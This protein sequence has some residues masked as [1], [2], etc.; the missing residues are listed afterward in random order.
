LLTGRLS[1]DDA[2]VLLPSARPV[3]VRGLQVHGERQEEVV[4]GQRVAVNLAGV[5]LTDVNRG[6]T[7]T[8]ADAVTVTRHADV[9][10]ELLRTG[11]PLKH[12]ARIRFHQGTRELLGRVVLPGI[13]EV[14]PGS[15]TYARLHL[16]APAVLVRGD[17]FILRACSPPETIAGGTILDPAAWRRGVRTAA[18]LARFASLST[19]EID[20]VTMM[21]DETERAGL[22][23]AQLTGRAGV[24]WERRRAVV[25][26]LVRDGVAIEISGVLVSAPRL[27]A[28]EDALIAAVTQYHASHPLEEGMPREE[29]RERLFAHATPPVF[30]QVLGTLSSRQRIV[31]RD[32]I[33]LAGHSVALTDE[34]GRARDAIVDTL[35]AAGFTP[36]DS[37]AL[38]AHINVPVEVVT[39]IATLLVRRSV[40]VR[41]G[42]LLFH[43]SALA[44]LKAEIQALRQSGA[45]ETIDVAS[46]K[47]RYHITRKYAI[48][49]LEYLDRERVTRRVGDSRKI[50]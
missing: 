29:V 33:A 17:R 44:R 46:F 16:A 18:G 21:I 32:R 50:L 7:L 26:R 4:A 10:L 22:P 38:A 45:V 20:A 30:E 49:L 41:V 25:D 12:G 11:R 1:L 19:S 35:R 48:P 37:S 36:P 40:L 27:S 24:A 39:R 9:C 42:D 28:V 43:E 31:G 14:A 13:R 2:L 47:D 5:E 3:R 15:S 8:C 34:E 6:E 23:V